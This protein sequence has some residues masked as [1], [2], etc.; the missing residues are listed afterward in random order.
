MAGVKVEVEGVRK[1]D[2]SLAAEKISFRRANNVRLESVATSVTAVSLTV[3]GKTVKVNALTQ[4]KDSRDDLKTFGQSNIAVN[5]S[6]QISAFLD[7]TTAPA[8]IVA[9]RVERVGAIGTNNRILQGPVDSALS[10]ILSILEYGGHAPF[11]RND[12]ACGPTRTEWRETTQADSRGRGGRRHRED[13][14]Q[15]GI[16]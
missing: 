4:Y 13:M 9:T 3:F 2:K 11:A 10:P 5:D 6:L 12:I 14:G 15:P 7:N 1:P 8:S 16:P